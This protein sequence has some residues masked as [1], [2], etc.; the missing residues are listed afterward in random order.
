MRAERKVSDDA[1]GK[2]VIGIGVAFAAMGGFIVLL[3]LGVID[4]EPGSLRAPVW[5]GVGAGLVFVLGGVVVVLQAIGG[6][7]ARTGELPPGAPRWMRV[8]QYALGLVIVIAMAT[9]GTWIA[10]GA[11]ER[12]FSGSLPVSA[13]V[14]RVV[15]GIGA[16]VVWI[17]VLLL[18][19]RAVTQI[20]AK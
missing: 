2:P 20:A 12:Q 8:A 16:A 1:L 11:G 17:Y 4:S 7:S 3:S 14:G 18:V 19:R 10:I 15:F 5:I 6:A 13:T 9:I